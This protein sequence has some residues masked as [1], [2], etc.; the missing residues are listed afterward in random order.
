M[1]VICIVSFLLLEN[2]EPYAND[3]QEH[4]CMTT[5]EKDLK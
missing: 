2:V 4:S 3:R 1:G 5:G